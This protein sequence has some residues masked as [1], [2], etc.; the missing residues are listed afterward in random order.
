M[1]GNSIPLDPVTGRTP[2]EVIPDHKALAERAGKD[3]R[4]HTLSSIQLK[5]RISYNDAAAVYAIYCGA[6]GPNR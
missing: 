4:V 5:F 1:R 6:V 2:W 3:A